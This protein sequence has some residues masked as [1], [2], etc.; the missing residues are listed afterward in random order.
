MKT[1]SMYTPSSEIGSK[2][3]ER[4]YFWGGLKKC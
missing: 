2:G 4:Y 1:A 3:E